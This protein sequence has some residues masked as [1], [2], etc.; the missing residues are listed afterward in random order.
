M[1]NLEDTEATKPK[2][3][4]GDAD[5][6][7]ERFRKKYHVADS[8]RTSVEMWANAHQIEGEEL[9]VCDQCRQGLTVH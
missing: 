7:E 9:A 1:N 3:I 6:S 4:A 5:M 8:I 2:I